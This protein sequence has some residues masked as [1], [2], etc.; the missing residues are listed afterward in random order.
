MTKDTW[1]KRLGWFLFYS[2][3]TLVIFYVLD[4]FLDRAVH[5]Y[6]NSNATVYFVDDYENETTQD[7]K[8]TTHDEETTT[9]KLKIYSSVKR[10]TVSVAIDGMEISKVFENTSDIEFDIPAN[11]GEYIITCNVHTDPRFGKEQDILL[12]RK[13]IVTK[14]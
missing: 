13:V 9:I 6:E 14:Q 10:F 2:A 8:V 12:T 5:N 11:D 3:I 4:F 7:I 1:Y